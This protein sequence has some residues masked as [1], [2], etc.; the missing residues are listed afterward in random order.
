MTLIF[1]QI[2]ERVK[3]ALNR[4][5]SILLLGPRQTG[6][7]TLV[8]SFHADLYI[9]LARPADRQ[10]Y[11]KDPGRLT[12]EVEAMTGKTPLVIIDEIQK[13]RPLLDA[14]QDLIDSQTAQFML[15][16]SS[17]RKLRRD[18]EANLL[19][20]RVV[21]LRMDPLL[22]DEMTHLPYSLEEL[23]LYGSLPEITLEK[24]IE[25]REEDLFSYVTTYLEEEI[26]AEALV[27]NI[28]AFGNFL[29]LAA[30][31]SGLI[32]NFHKLSQDVG[33]SS[34]TIGEYY[35]ILVDCLVAE[36]VEPLSLSRTR[37]K[38]VKSPKFLIYDLGVRRIAAG[39]GRDIPDKYMGNLFEQWVGLE[40]LRQMRTAPIKSSLMFWRDS[41]GAEVDW[42]VEKT[43]QYIPVEVKW[44]ENPQARDAR[45]IQTFL[46]EYKN[47]SHGYLIC[48][49]PRAQKLA[50]NVTAL[51]WQEL[52]KV[53]EGVVKS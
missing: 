10:V 2:E 9:N 7:T 5:K 37:K 28:G 1:R 6:K 18:G 12:R 32:S 16:G 33:V 34:P 24:S 43:N 17:A 39:E 22:I 45:H 20:G 46:N 25:N 27:R 4:K 36:R 51:P 42:V 38:L 19:P 14:A 53:L 15:T 35:Q 21:A 13:V 11:E 31:E 50:P 29:D 30:L 52:P 40:L 41:S 8:K 49:I 48:R 3:K 23:L 44:T 47:S 26:R